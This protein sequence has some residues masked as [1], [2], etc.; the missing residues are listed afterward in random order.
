MNKLNKNRSINQIEKFLIRRAKTPTTADAQA[1]AYL[2]KCK[3]K[4]KMSNSTYDYIINNTTIAHQLDI[5][6]ALARTIVVE[7]TGDVL[8]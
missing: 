6:D 7:Y 2:I 3:D 4:V 5:S 1:L 8:L